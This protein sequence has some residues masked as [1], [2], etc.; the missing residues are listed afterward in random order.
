M[1]RSLSWIDEGRWNR[2]L[3]E[4]GLT[5]R[6]AP[7][8]PPRWSRL[9]VE[10]G[11]GSGEA[12]PAMHRA[13][14]REPAPPPVLEGNLDD[15]LR[16]LLFWVTRLTGADL[17]F[18]SDDSGLPLQ[19]VGAAANWVV[20]TAPLMEGFEMVRNAVGI[21]DPGLCSLELKK[22]NVLTLV[23]ADVEWGRF[24]LGFVC[25]HTADSAALRKIQAAFHLALD[26]KGESHG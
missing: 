25:D 24:A 22:G 8:V 15:R 23:E 19:T 4:A 13:E 3:S 26:E 2:L 9:P 6:S 11:Q 5:E 10:P 12:K 18:I 21:E 1:S 20:A 14:P 17:L 7:T 16:Q